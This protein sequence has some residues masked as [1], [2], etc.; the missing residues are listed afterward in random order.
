M[1]YL[2]D[3]D[4]MRLG[5]DWPGLADE[6][7]KIAGLLQTEAIA[8][9]L[10]PYLRFGD[11]ANR[12]I[13]MPAYV[14]GGIEAC[15][16]KWI[17]SFPGNRKLGLPRAHNAI[18][19][20]DPDT[21]EPIAFFRS[22]LLNAL[23]TAAVSGAM[24]RGWLKRRPDRSL[25]AGIVGWGPIG[26]AHLE[27]LRALLGDR[28]A[29]TLLFDANGIAP[30][31]VPDDLRNSVVIAGSWREAYRHADIFATCTTAPER[32]IDEPPPPGA[33][34]LN[35]SLRDY[36]PH[37]VR[38]LAAVV[39]DDWR[40]VCRENTDIERLHQAFGLGERDTVTL[41]QVLHEDALGRFAAD[42]P[43]FFNPMGMAAFDIGIARRYYELALRNYAGRLLD[44]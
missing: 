14:G 27:M 21:G 19:L 6:A 16:I 36:M 38:S 31:T 1:I 44:G 42:E 2:N 12:I 37:S 26:R 35:V 5:V 10:K 7:E 13:A 15:G 20:N 4:I 30:E 17:A 32:Y 18:I 24:L 3:G 23:R 29:W 8:Q 9:P 40:E 25:T 28:L 33:L 41:K 39:V 22:G 11:P 43:V 34:L